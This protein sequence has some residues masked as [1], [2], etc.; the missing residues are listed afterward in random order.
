MRDTG[1]TPFSAWMPAIAECCDSRE[2]GA[3]LARLQAT[4][5]AGAEG[6][7][8]GIQ[9]Y[10]PLTMALVSGVAAT[11]QGQPRWPL[12]RRCWSLGAAARGCEVRVRSCWVGAG[13]HWGRLHVCVT[14][15]WLGRWSCS[16]SWC[17]AR[18]SVSDGVC[19][20]H[21]LSHTADTRR[22][23]VHKTMPCLCV[24]MSD[25]RLLS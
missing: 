21:D 12:E 24:V 23:Y 15:A 4:D 6:R 14:G 17:L 11:W 22:L 1:K 9:V 8:A 20:F 10:C 25:S 3:C 7:P 19:G 13:W 18:Q 16:F 2:G 5:A